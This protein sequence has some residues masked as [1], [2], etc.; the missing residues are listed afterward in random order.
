MDKAL[1]EDP[2]NINA[3][4]GYYHL[5]DLTAEEKRKVVQLIETAADNARE[6]IRNDRKT[7][8]DPRESMY[9]E[10]REATDCNQFAWLI[11]NTEGNFDEAFEIRA[12]GG[13]VAA[14]QRR[15]LRHSRTRLLR[16]GRLRKRG[17][18]RRESPRIRAAFGNDRKEIGGFRKSAGGE[19]KV[20]STMPSIS[21]DN[22]PFNYNDAGRGV[23]LLLAHGFPLDHTMWNGQIAALSGRS[24]VIAPDLRGFGGS[25]AS[26]GAATMEQMADDLAALLDAL[27]IREPVVLCGLSMG[28]Y[29]AFEFWRK[30]AA[31]LKAL[32]LCDTRAAADKPQAAADR[33]AMADRVLREGPRPLVESMLPKLFSPRTSA[34]QPRIVREIE[35][36]M[37]LS[38]SAGHRRGGPGDGPAPRFHRRTEKHPLPGARARRRGRRAIHARRN[39]SA[40][41]RDPACPISNSPRRRPSRAPRAARHCQR[42]DR[43]VSRKSRIIDSQVGPA[44]R[45]G[46][47]DSSFDFQPGTRD[48]LR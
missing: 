11:A 14:G 2:G 15:H 38:R 35:S 7:P 8:A 5:P 19:E 25:G 27:A 39:A 1:K 9:A 22:I 46:P 24:R 6:A 16:Q 20:K 47:F 31:K 37:M 33:L 23:P 29:I 45:A 41:R 34:D 40:G 17:Q 48:F 30:Y 28:G 18:N 44:C 32:I 26:E 12:A 13:R 21:I 36:L 3:L 10:L 4:I 43:V 42:G